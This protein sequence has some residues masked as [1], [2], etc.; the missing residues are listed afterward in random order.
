ME[1][2]NTGTPP[3]PDAIRRA[4]GIAEE[5]PSRGPGPGRPHQDVWLGS[6]DALRWVLGLRAT[7]PLSG[8]DLPHDPDGTAALAE[9]DYADACFHGGR[10]P[11]GGPGTTTYVLGAQDALI[12]VLN[13]NS[14][15]DTLDDD[16]LRTGYLLD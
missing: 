14:F 13:G 16:A 4:L 11:V 6:A 8:Q 7:T 1:P 9:V 2:L 3:T 15:A 12:W 10:L 5:M